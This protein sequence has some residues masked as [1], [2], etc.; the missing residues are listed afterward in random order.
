M[1]RSRVLTAGAACVAALGIAW[2]VAAAGSDEPPTAT[3]PTS[4]QEAPQS[5][6]SEPSPAPTAS[7]P[8]PSPT[9]RASAAALP[10]PVRGALK[11]DG[12]ADD[13][14]APFLD[15]EAL[16]RSSPDD[17]TDLDSVATGVALSDLA[18]EAADLAERGVTQEGRPVVVSATVTEVDMAGKPPTA[19]VAL[20][21]DYA[22]V[23]LVAED[24]TSMV[25]PSASTRAAS[26][27]ELVQ[28]DGAWLVSRRT[29]PD[30]PSC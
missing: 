8:S 20:C 18:A 14:V 13:V 23:D 28:Q 5:P 12:D 19:V 10:S 16:A 22:D 15:G 29:F 4:T 21:L 30:D 11:K 3:A 27:L 2:A 26:I 24:G 6:S 1:R 17:D 9:P 25:D 7:S